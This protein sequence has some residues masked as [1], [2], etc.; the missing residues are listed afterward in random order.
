MRYPFYC[1]KCG[2]RRDINMLITEY[3][4]KNHMCPDC[5]TEMKHDIASFGSI[6]VDKTNSF[7]RHTSI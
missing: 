2:A 4:D 3:T 6:A 7:F 5:G 1:P